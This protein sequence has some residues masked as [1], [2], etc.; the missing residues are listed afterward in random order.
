M[1]TVRCRVFF[2]V[3]IVI[4]AIGG[5]AAPIMDISKA[6]SA[7]TGFFA[8]IDT[9]LPQTR[10]FKEP[11]ASAQQDIK[12]RDVSFTYPSRREVKVLDNVSIDFAAGQLTAIVGPSGSG[13][14]TIVALIERWYHIASP[15]S[16]LEERT[17]PE[18]SKQSDVNVKKLDVEVPQAELGSITVGDFEIQSLDLKWWRSQIG[19][20]QQ[21]PFTFNATI[22]QNVAYGLIGSRWELEND[23]IKLELVKEACK[24][25]FA[26]EF[27]NRLPLVCHFC[28]LCVG[29]SLT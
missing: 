7:S 14:S 23:G 20:V 22:Y 5:V 28:I 3:L 4:S 8:M 24:E 26:D 25:S 17:V 16:E 6:S 10:G 21:E 19:L 9:P 13:K 1:T 2:S 11:E 18:N 12:F 27:I 15:V 29:S